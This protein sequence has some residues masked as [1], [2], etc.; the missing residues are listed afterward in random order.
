MQ[1][2]LEK[3]GK[4]LRPQRAGYRAARERHP[5]PDRGRPA[6]PSRVRY[7][8]LRRPL[9]GCILPLT[10]FAPGPRRTMA[11][12]VA[13]MT[14]RRPTEEQGT[15]PGQPSPDRISALAAAFA[16][17]AILLPV[18]GVV[19]RFVAFSLSN[20]VV[21]PSL[22]ATARLSDLATLGLT[23]TGPAILLMVGIVAIMKIIE[24]QY[25]P[26]ESASPRF[27]PTHGPVRNVF[28]GLV[29]AAAG[30]AILWALLFS[31]GFPGLHL[32]LLN[33][34]VAGIWISRRLRTARAVP[35]WWSWT[36]LVAVLFAG[37]AISYGLTPTQVGP[38]VK[39]TTLPQAVA[40]TADYSIPAADDSFTFLARCDSRDPVVG[41]PSSMIQSLTFIK[42]DDRPAVSLV[43][44]LF[45]HQDLNVGY[46][47]GC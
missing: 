18:A 22:A 32:G 24:W 7:A 45:Q 39:V 21:H 16:V 10:R 1:I 15:G 44:L 41:I 27:L 19:T 9:T 38:V 34:L 2:R 33:G 11:H 14:P 23:V 37:T 26:T 35:T 31:P 29:P 17:A 43:G 46:W 36:P 25:S 28:G 12:V 4:G 6:R 20:G 47:R 40:T 13:S 3:L 30:L 8:R 42:P 5:E